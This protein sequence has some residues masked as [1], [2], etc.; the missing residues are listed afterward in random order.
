VKFLLCE[1]VTTLHFLNLRPNFGSIRLQGQSIEDVQ[2]KVGGGVGQ[3]WRP[4]PKWTKGS[5][6]NRSSRKKNWPDF[7]FW[8]DFFLGFRIGVWHRP[9]WIAI[10]FALRTFLRSLRS[11][12]TRWGECLPNGRCWTGWRVQKVSFCPDVFDGWPLTPPSLIL[13]SPYSAYTIN[14]QTSSA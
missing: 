14:N 7:F 8:P 9:P 10:Y 5:A 11:G 6:I 1:F 13:P 4:R 3:S 2:S 12:R